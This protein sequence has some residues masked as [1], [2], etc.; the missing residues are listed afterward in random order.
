MQSVIW[1]G[2]DI[3]LFQKKRKKRKFGDE[4]LFLENVEWKF[5]KV[6]KL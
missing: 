3:G 5:E 2:Y 1:C 4:N 6:V